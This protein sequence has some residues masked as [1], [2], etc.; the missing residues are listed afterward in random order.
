[1]KKNPIEF[2][3]HDVFVKDLKINHESLY[4]FYQKN[5]LV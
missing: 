4:S 1:M 2:I 3:Y 5:T